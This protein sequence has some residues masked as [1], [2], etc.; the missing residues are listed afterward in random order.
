MADEPQKDVLKKDSDTAW[1]MTNPQSVRSFTAAG[2]FFGRELRRRRCDDH[3]G[4]GLELAEQTRVTDTPC[5]GIELRARRDV[6]RPSGHAVVDKRACAR[7]V[8]LVFD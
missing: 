7:R 8:V 1:Q 2:Y 3:A 5:R 6:E 4:Q